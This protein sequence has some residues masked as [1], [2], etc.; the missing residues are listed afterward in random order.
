MISARDS[1]NIQTKPQVASVWGWGRERLQPRTSS[2]S[3]H[4]ITNRLCS[5]AMLCP[6]STY[7]TN[8]RSTHATHSLYCL[9]PSSSPSEKG[10]HPSIHPSME[11]FAAAEEKPCRLFKKRSGG[12]GKG[13]M[14]VRADGSGK[15]ER[16]TE[17]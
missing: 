10:R 16:M 17:L 9:S 15:V 13:G 6:S 14:G 3:L 11:L 5:Y 1:N 7:K 12:G 8:R 2:S 4:Y